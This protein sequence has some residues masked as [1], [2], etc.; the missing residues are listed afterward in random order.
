M[1][2]LPQNSYVSAAVLCV[3]VG[4][5]GVAGRGKQFQCQWHGFKIKSGFSKTILGMPMSPTHHVALCS[6]SFWL[7]L[8]FTL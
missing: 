2:L 8:L 4:G 1:G 7:N 6:F 5:G 3:S